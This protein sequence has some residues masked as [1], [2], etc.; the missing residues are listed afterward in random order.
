MLVRY[1]HFSPGAVI[2]NRYQE[3]VD[4]LEH[5]FD[6]EFDDTLYL[7]RELRDRNNLWIDT[8]ECTLNFSIDGE[9]NLWVDIDGKN[10]FWAASE[11]TLDAAVEIL[12]IA[13][14]GGPFDEHIPT[15]DQEWG[16]YSGT[17]P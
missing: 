11:I 13:I 17:W 6:L 5:E 2:R 1:K 4:Y 7:L 14:A 3:G 9:A 12:R 8:P 16:A 15:T 10:N